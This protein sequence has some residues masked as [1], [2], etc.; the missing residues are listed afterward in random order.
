MSLDPSNVALFLEVYEI[1]QRSNG[2]LTLIPE[3]K[4]LLKAAFKPLKKVIASKSLDDE[5][6]F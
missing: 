3:K 6:P 1:C 2:L 5:I 4:W